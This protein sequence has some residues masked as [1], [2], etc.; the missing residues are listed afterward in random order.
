MGRGSLTGCAAHGT[1]GT[2]RVTGDAQPAL[3]DR[4]AVAGA[5]ARPQVRSNEVAGII[6]TG[7]HAVA[8]GAGTAA[9][10]TG[11]RLHT[12]S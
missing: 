3:V 11:V 12:F 4:D 7:C 5:L 2:E 1:T 8:G 10:E 9:G 6:N